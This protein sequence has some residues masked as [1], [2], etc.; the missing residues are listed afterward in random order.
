MNYANLEK[1]ISIYKSIS[2]QDEQTFNKLSQFFKI[3]SK[4]GIIFTEKVKSSLEEFI[5]EINKETRN[6][7]YTISLSRFCLD[8]KQFL[9][10]SKLVFSSI[11]KNIVE[12][13]NEFISENK[14][15]SEDNNNKLYNILVKLAEN[16]AKIEKYKYSYFDACKVMIEQEK[17]MKEKNKN[18]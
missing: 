5:Q 4:Q 17:K 10:G 16:K 7:T 13:I 8:I 9:D 2:N 14:L 12:K 18:K 6:T 11:E 3:I 1:E 15:N